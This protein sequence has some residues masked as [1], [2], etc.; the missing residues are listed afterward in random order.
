MEVRIINRDEREEA[1]RLVEKTFMEYEA[2]DYPE[3]GIETFKN[4]VFKSEKFLQSIVIYGAFEENKIVGIIATRNG[5][6]HI[7]L[8]F[9]DGAHHR[10]GIGRKLFE[11][12]LKDCP[13]DTMTVNSSPYAVE[14]YHHFG[15]VD[16]DKEQLT[17]GIR[18]TPMVLRRNKTSVGF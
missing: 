16:T 4:S 15:F 7:A 18:Y 9:V 14:V 8:F 17:D 11:T 6:S 3:K 10:N 1:L 5:G 13:G 2:P 12:A